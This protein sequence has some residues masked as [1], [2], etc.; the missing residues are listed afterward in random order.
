MPGGERLEKLDAVPEGV[1]HVDVVEVGEEL[2][3]DDLESSRAA[4]LHDVPE[5]DHEHRGVCFARREEVVID[6]EMHLG[7][8]RKEPD[9]ATLREVLGP[10]SFRHSENAREERPRPGLPPSGHR[11]LHVM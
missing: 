5:A 2:V 8:P 3:S 9:A 1:G 6:S 7:R 10:D 11:K 4:S